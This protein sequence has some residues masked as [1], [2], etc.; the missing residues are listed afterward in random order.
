MV[1]TIVS[2][3]LL[4]E[5]SLLNTAEASRFLG[6]S[7]KSIIRY[8]KSERNTLPHVLVNGNFRF[9]INDLIV[10]KRYLEKIKNRGDQNV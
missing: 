8:C 9:T 7:S 10:Y 4:K 5:K 1:N 6:V 2:M 3:K